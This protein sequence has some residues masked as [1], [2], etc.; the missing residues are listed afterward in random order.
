MVVVGRSKPVAA[1]APTAVQARVPASITL[2]RSAIQWELMVIVLLAPQNAE[3]TQRMIRQPRGK[4]APHMQ[5]HPTLS[6]QPRAFILYVM[7][8]HPIHQMLLTVTIAPGRQ[9]DGSHGSGCGLVNLCRHGGAGTTS[10]NRKPNRA[11][12]ALLRGRCPFAV[13]VLCVCFLLDWPACIS[14]REA[15]QCRFHALRGIKP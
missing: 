3:A 2:P 14:R 1:S 8:Q 5:S 9:T 6:S 10:G 4:L 11:A 7:R 15:L 12:P 13:R